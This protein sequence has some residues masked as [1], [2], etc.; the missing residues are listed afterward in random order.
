ME[1]GKPV[2]GP[3]TAGRQ[4]LFKNEGKDQEVNLYTYFFKRIIIM[5]YYF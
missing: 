1:K 2:P 4:K 5:K 3:G